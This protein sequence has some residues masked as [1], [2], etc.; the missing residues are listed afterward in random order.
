MKPKDG[1]CCV[2][3]SY[4]DKKCPPMQVT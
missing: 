4:V 1:D 2:F 3:Y